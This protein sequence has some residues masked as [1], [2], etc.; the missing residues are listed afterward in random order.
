MIYN[1]SKLEEKL[2][3]ICIREK[4]L[5]SKQQQQNCFHINDMHILK[6][7]LMV[8][9][10]RGLFLFLSLGNKLILIS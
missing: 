5:V 7:F 2:T 4:S 6:S 1:L 9:A 10:R 8:T 3:L